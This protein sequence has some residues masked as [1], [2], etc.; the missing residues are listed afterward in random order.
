MRHVGAVGLQ[1]LLD[2][3]KLLSQHLL[4]VEA[5]GWV[6]CGHGK[7]KQELLS[8]PTIT[9][10]EPVIMYDG[11]DVSERP[12]EHSCRRP[13]VRAKQGQRNKKLAAYHLVCHVSQKR[14]VNRIVGFNLGISQ[15][16]VVLT[17]QVL[18]ARAEE[19]QLHW[20]AKIQKSTQELGPLS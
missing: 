6:I 13:V 17:S 14:Q 3:C 1:D 5:E 20:N 19:A 12:E 15:R 8:S 18:Q 16:V 9:Q 7:E 4:L 2:L 10:S 11:I